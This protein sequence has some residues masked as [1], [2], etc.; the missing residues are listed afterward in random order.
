[1]YIPKI[2]EEKDLQAIIDFMRTF[3]F[4]TLINVVNRKIKASH[5]PVITHGE[6]NQIRIY[7]H[8][9]KANNLLSHTKTD[10]ECLLI[11]QGPNSYISSTWYTKENVP[12]W[13]YIAVHIYGKIRILDRPSLKKIS[14]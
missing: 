5:I 1:M 10:D 2:F 9:S 12:T 11:F 7:G 13:N 3:P 14:G 4:A 8:I 6:K